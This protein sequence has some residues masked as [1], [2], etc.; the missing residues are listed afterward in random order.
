MDHTN[1]KQKLLQLHEQVMQAH[2]ESDVA[3]LFRA[4]G[5]TY[6]VA[7]RGQVS[8]PESEARR[9]RFELYFQA[10]RFEEYTDMIPPIVQVSADGTLGWVIAQIYARGVQ[11]VSGG[12]NETLE[13][14]S[15]WI[16]L[17]EKRDGDWLRVGNV[18]NFKP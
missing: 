5:D 16:E 17:Y 11:T 7:N 3:L 1:E 14:E 15:A 8:M 10:T 9:A 18:S 2:R 12:T 6:T 13:F 4:E